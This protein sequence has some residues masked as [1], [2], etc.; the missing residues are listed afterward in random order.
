MLSHWDQIRNN[1]I[2]NND[3]YYLQSNNKMYYLQQ[4]SA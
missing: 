1:L 4:S 3:D 2:S